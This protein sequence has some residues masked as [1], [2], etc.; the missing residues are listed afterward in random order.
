MTQRE[1][2]A[3]LIVLLGGR[4]A[5]MN[6]FG[7]PS[8]RAEDD[9]EDAAKLARRMV[10][11]WGMA[12]GFVLSGREPDGA[13]S[14]SMDLQSAPGVGKL[15]GRAQ[16]AARTILSDNAARLAAIAETLVDRE[17]L[18]IAE[19]GALAGLRDRVP[20]L[21]EQAPSPRSGMRPVSRLHG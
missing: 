3:Q 6:T 16:H 9:L 2:M 5:E 7:E 19:I 18:T 4:A 17:T 11:R 15:L 21:A 10:E 8:T 13:A 14:G 1:L 12:G 20:E